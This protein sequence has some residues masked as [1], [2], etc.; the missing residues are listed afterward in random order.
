MENK[1]TRETLVIPNGECE[2]VI[3]NNQ[4]KPHCVK[5]NRMVIGAIEPKKNKQI[6]IVM[7]S[8]FIYNGEIYHKTREY[9][10]IYLY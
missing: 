7:G 6:Q 8:G 2:L 9:I 3:E 5:V 10:Y 1:T 4:P